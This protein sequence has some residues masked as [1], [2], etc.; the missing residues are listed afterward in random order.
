M[1]ATTTWVIPSVSSTIVTAE[2]TNLDVTLVDVDGEFLSSNVL[3]LLFEKF[4][5]FFMT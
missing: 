1:G 4:T 3:H 5:V 2:F